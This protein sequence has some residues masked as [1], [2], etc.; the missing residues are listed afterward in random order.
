LFI[1]KEYIPITIHSIV[2]TIHFT[3]PDYIQ[4]VISAL[5]TKKKKEGREQFVFM[6]KGGR[7]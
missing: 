7:P 1:N 4:H 5:I 6:K 2:P 3:V